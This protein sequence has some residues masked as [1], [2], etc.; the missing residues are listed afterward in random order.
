MLPVDAAR[1]AA[2]AEILHERLRM[3]QFARRVLGMLV[4]CIFIAAAVIEIHVA[5]WY[6]LADALGPKWTPLLIAAGDIVLAFAALAT[7]S[8]GGRL[9]RQ[10]TEAAELRNRALG[11]AGRA[12]GLFTVIA[13]MLALLRGRGRLG[14]ALAAAAGTLLFRRR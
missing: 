10:A 8:H 5:A 14:A 6:L 1:T 9:E 12:V 4:A 2:R 7:A 13:P 11:E 3:Q